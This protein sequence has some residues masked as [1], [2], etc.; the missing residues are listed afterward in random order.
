MAVADHEHGSGVPSGSSQ[1][2]NA[3]LLVAG[4]LLWAWH[5]IRHGAGWA[6]WIKP[7]VLLAAGGLTAHRS[8][9]GIADIALLIAAYLVLDAVASFSP[10][11][12]A[13]G[14]AG[15]GWMIFKGIADIVL[16]G[17]FL[18]GWPQSS[19]WMVGLFVGISLIF[20]GWALVAIG[21]SLR[22]TKPARNGS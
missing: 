13:S 21:W 2:S 8:W 15:R 9:A 6:D 12:N 14:K 19:L 5:S 17:L 10:A 18:W 11:G 4:G 1:T 16:A 7:V 22:H 20:D 3:S